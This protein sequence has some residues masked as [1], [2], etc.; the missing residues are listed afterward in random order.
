[1]GINKLTSYPSTLPEIQQ[2]ID[3]V[4]RLMLA[5][6]D[7]YHSDLKAVLSILLSSG[8]KRIR[9]RII[10]L[11]GSIFHAKKET[12]ITLAASIELLHTAT[13]VHASKRSPNLE[14]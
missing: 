6:A 14:F 4:E 7:E 10:L 13:L 8:G 11:L 9:P 5:Q 2:G 12:L 1:L 3:T